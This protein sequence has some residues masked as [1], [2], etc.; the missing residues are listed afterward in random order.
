[1]IP[2]SSHSLATAPRSLLPNWIAAGAMLT[3]AA[4]TGAD[5]TSSRALPSDPMLQGHAIWCGSNPPSG[6]CPGGYKR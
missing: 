1:M 6:Y 3:L 4:C 5:R 2:R